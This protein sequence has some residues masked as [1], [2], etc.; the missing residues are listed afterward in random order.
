MLRYNNDPCDGLSRSSGERLNVIGESAGGE[1][2][3]QLTCHALAFVDYLAPGGK[4]LRIAQAIEVVTVRDAPSGQARHVGQ[5][6]DG[7]GI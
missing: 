3:A 7:P 4:T 5:L 1:Q 6:S 2:L